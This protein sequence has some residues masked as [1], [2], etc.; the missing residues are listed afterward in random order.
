MFLDKFV[1][2]PMS[3]CVI[4]VSFFNSIAIKIHI[5]D[6]TRQLLDTFGKFVV[7]KRG[8]INIKVTILVLL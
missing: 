8:W 2:S 1:L 6:S 3:T 5:S 7:E 4:N